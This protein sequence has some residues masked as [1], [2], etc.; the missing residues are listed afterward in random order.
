[1]LFVVFVLVLEL[2]SAYKAGYVVLATS[3]LATVGLGTSPLRLPSAFV[4][5]AATDPAVLIFSAPLIDVGR[6]DRGPLGGEGVVRCEGGGAPR[7]GGL[8]VIF[9]VTR[10]FFLSYAPPSKRRSGLCASLEYSH[11]RGSGRRWNGLCG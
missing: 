9:F 5:L 11:V 2:K 7:G 6:L 3:A 8:S 4:A 10:L 1:M